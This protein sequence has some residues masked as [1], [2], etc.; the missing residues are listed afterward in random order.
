MAT[1]PMAAPA[2]P[3]MMDDAQEGQEGAEQGV[4]VCITAMPDG[5]FEVKIDEDGQEDEEG[6]DETGDGPQMA[7][8]LD[9][10]LNMAGEMLQAEMGEEQG[11][12]GAGDEPMA[13][14]Q[15]KMAWDA[16]ASKRDKA[17]MAG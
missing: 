4:T 7:K 10:A 6:G 17:R 12:S 8:T 3:T 5:T 1:A 13:P 16:M 14:D 15:A 11:E 9:E 2:D